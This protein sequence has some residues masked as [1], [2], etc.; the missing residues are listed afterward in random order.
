M[1]PVLKLLNQ[2][3]ERERVSK[4]PQ[5]THGWVNAFK[6]CEHQCVT[7]ICNTVLFA[8]SLIST[9]SMLISRSST[10]NFSCVGSTW[11]DSIM[12]VRCASYTAD[13]VGSGCGRWRRPLMPSTLKCDNWRRLIFHSIA[14][15]DRNFWLKKS[16]VF[17]MRWHQLHRNAL[18]V[19]S[20]HKPL[21]GTANSTCYRHYNRLNGVVI[22]H[23]MALFKGNGMRR[24]VAAPPSNGIAYFC[25]QIIKFRTLY[26]TFGKFS[27]FVNAR[28]LAHSGRALAGWPSLRMHHAHESRV[29]WHSQC[30]RYGQSWLIRASE[31]FLLE[32]TY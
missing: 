16:D 9:H 26:R 17:H 14:S 8:I 28:T 27:R 2:T 22:V 7:C 6:S 32:I 18:R 31:S 1:K 20:K 12:C 10:G 25:L 24:W 4:E 11:C 3:R 23:I 19:V 30:D 13:F 5:K 15:S 29:G 21:S